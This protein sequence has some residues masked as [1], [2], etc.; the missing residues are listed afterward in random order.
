MPNVAVNLLSIDFLSGA[1]IMLTSSQTDLLGHYSITYQFNTEAQLALFVTAASTDPACAN[2]SVSTS[3][4][5]LTVSPPA[6]SAG[7][8][9]LVLASAP[10][11][12]G[13][14]LSVVYKN[15]TAG[16]LSA[17]IVADIRNSIGQTIKT[18]T[19]TLTNIPAGGT[20]GAS[21]SLAGPPPGTYTVLFFAVTPSGIVLSAT[22]QVSVVL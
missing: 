14:S 18:T 13:T 19:A 4:I 9:E 7:P 2:F 3:Q 10:V 16:P 8:N 5:S 21:L 11:Q 22:T 6:P 1:Q 15:T 17:I 20:S 12:S